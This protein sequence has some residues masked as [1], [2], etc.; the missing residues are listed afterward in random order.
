MAGG[1]SP[2]IL[3][4]AG[5]VAE[6]ASEIMVQWE[7]SCA[8][9]PALDGYHLPG[10]AQTVIHSLSYALL[11]AQGLLATIDPVLRTAAVTVFAAD[12]SLVARTRQLAHVQAVIRDQ[13]RYQATSELSELTQRLNDATYS[14]IEVIT[15]ASV[16]Q[17]Q[18]LAF[19]DELTGLRNRVAYEIDRQEALAWAGGNRPVSTVMI[20]IDGLKEVNDSQGHDV[21]NLLLKRFAAALQDAIAGTAY[22][23]AGDEFCALLRDVGAVA[24]SDLIAALEEREGGPSFSW[25][26]ACLNE[27]F[28]SWDLVEKLAD[29]RM[30]AMKKAKKR[31]NLL[32]CLASW[33]KWWVG[34]AKGRKQKRSG[35]EKT[36][37]PTTD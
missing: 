7:E 3:R 15:E 6:R 35:Q 8:Q 14:M 24:A 5:L 36:T 37:P 22:R 1:T 23:W 26:I 31:P 10:D 13:I 18:Q 21:G 29:Q 32:K 25:G 11:T 34:R 2:E 28:G 27:D 20:D 30:Y 12:E 19:R 9:D 33:T 16:A 17:L 4:V